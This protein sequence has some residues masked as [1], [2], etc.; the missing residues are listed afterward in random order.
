MC[1]QGSDSGASLVLWCFVLNPHR[2]SPYPKLLWCHFATIASLL[3]CVEVRVAVGQNAERRCAMAEGK[4]AAG[5]K[6][7]RLPRTLAGALGTRLTRLGLERLTRLGLELRLETEV[8]LESCRESRSRLESL[9][10]EVDP[11]LELE[12]RR[13]T[14]RPAR[15][16][17]ELAGRGGEV[18]H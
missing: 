7:C 13:S 18:A 8:R 6:G 11:L 3:L 16:P 17:S 4:A 1:S 15:P 14:E 9:S 12:S 5:L 10:S 2:G